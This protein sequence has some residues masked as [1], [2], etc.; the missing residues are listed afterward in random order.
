MVNEILKETP[1]TRIETAE[2]SLDSIKLNLNFKPKGSGMSILNTIASDRA[3]FKCLHQSIIIKVIDSASQYLYS[4]LLN[5]IVL[6][7]FG[8]DWD[9]NGQTNV[10]ND[11]EIACGFFVSTT[12]K[13]F[14]FILNRYKMAQ[15]AGLIEVRMLQSNSELKTHRNFSFEEL[16]TN[17]NLV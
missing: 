3:Y 13:H 9:F 14:G 5:D 11:V 15:Q 8:S 10:P 6:H 7:W 1:N 16:K 17:I 4:K 12:L 2:P